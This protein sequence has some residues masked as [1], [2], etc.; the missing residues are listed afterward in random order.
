MYEN[1]VQPLVPSDVFSAAPE[2]AAEYYVDAT[3][4]GETLGQWN[5]DSEF[6]QLFRQSAQES[7]PQPTEHLPVPPRVDRRRR[8]TRLVGLRDPRFLKIAIAGTTAAVAT[9]I[10]G[11][12]A[13]VSYGPLRILAFPTAH[14][15]AGLWPL[16]VYGPWLVSCLSI[17]HAAAHRRQVKAAWVTLILFSG[18]AV[19]LCIAYAPRTVT[20]IVTAGLPPVSALV[21]FYLLVGQITLLDPRHAKAKLPRQRKH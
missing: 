20:A 13:L 2:E 5:L 7:Q 6:E 1:D 15:L 17:L 10:S 14:S 21:S 3:P 8:R 18:V 19:A 12:G 9:V 11:L 4:A 16:L